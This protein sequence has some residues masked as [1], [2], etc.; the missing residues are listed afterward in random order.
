MVNTLFEILW[1][2]IIVFL[3]WFRGNYQTKLITWR[4]STEE[5][6]DVFLTYS[7]FL[8]SSHFFCFQYRLR[9]NGKYCVVWNRRRVLRVDVFYR[10]LRNNPRITPK[11]VTIL[12]KKLVLINCTYWFFWNPIAWMIRKKAASKP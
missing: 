4:A 2:D 11:F 9:A 1:Y 10:N 6:N 12:N 8:H 5:A 7:F 3:W